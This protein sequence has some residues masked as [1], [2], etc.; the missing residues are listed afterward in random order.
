M[1][2][3]A[4]LGEHLGLE[5]GL[6]QGVA[7]LERVVADRVVWREDR[8]DLVDGRHSAASGGRTVSSS[9]TT[10][11]SSSSTL[12]AVARMARAVATPR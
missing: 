8:D 3:E 1:L 11:C 5:P 10:R 7:Q 2:P 6:A 4:H 9:A 12:A